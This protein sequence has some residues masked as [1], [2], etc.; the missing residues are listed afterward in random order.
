MKIFYSTEI[1]RTF[2]FL[3]TNEVICIV[4]NIIIHSLN[5]RYFL[6]FRII[7]RSFANYKR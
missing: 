7:V 4:I 3:L 1:I 6:S 5:V 2:F